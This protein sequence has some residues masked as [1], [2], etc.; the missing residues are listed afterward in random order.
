MAFFENLKDSIPIVSL[1]RK[2][3]A[4]P[5]ETKKERQLIVLLNSLFV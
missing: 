4:N 2:D 5:I 1:N 3:I